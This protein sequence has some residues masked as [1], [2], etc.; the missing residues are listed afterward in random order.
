MFPRG[1]N[2]PE[3]EEGCSPQTG[4]GLQARPTACP[5][6][7]AL[8]LPALGGI[9]VCDPC[10]QAMVLKPEG[11]IRITW[12]GLF[13][14][15]RYLHPK[16]IWRTTA[17]NS[18]QSISETEK[19]C[20]FY[21]PKDISLCSLTTEAKTDSTTKCVWQSKPSINLPNTFKQPTNTD[22]GGKKSF[23]IFHFTLIKL[24]KCLS[25][26]NQSG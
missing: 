11:F 23:K 1:Q 17:S 5:H 3:W 14:L 16:Y 24:V 21:L 10:S 18:I 26:N 20:Y 15:P 2:Q 19:M 25:Q 4:R 9:L 12:R 13:T 6:H 8:P 22:K 7:P